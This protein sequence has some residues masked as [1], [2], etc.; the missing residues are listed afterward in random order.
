MAAERWRKKPVVIEACR[1]DR[2]P[3]A[4]TV[5]DEWADA[6]GRP[7]KGGTAGGSLIITTLEG[8]HEAK[9]GDYI[10]RG[11]QGEIYP[12]KPDIFLATYEQVQ[13]DVVE[14]GAR[15]A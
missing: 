1:W 8:D 3:E 4:L 7:L 9:V 14:G 6:C 12:C 15:D 11:V 10:I 5:I 13:S 2:T